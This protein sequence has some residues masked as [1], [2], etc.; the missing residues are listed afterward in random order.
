MRPGEFEYRFREPYA[1]PQEKGA[2]APV[3]SRTEERSMIIERNV[4]V[5][6]RDG[7]KILVDIFRPAN[8]QPAPPI[9]AFTPYGKHQNGSASY[10]ANPGCEVTPD[11]V[12]AYATFEGPD[13]LYWVPHGYALVHADIRGTW[14]SEGDATFVSPQN[15]ED[16]YDLIEWAGHATMEQRASWAPPACPILPRCATGAKQSCATAAFGCHNQGRARAIPIANSRATAGT[17]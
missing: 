10:S 16:F 9:I 13:P 5:A 1:T 15:A 2:P 17:A 11:M 7:V 12:S 4:A 14:Y 8:E 6:M 3:Q